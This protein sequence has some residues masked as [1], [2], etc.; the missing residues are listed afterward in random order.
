VNYKI[1]FSDCTQD[2]TTFT[3][4]ATFSGKNIS[5]TSTSYTAHLLKLLSAGTQYFK[6]LLEGGTIYYGDV[7]TYQLLL[8]NIGPVRME[9]IHFEDFLPP[10]LELVS[11][12]I[13]S[14]Q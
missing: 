2:N 1:N 11:A 10:E 9:D 14:S 4:T 8:S 3:N 13:I 6:T 7:I 5:P 12:D